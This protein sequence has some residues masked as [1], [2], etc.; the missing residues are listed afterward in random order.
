LQEKLTVGYRQIVRF[1]NNDVA[2]LR[3]RSKLTQH[4]GVRLQEPGISQHPEQ[5]NCVLS[6][7]R[8][9]AG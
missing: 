2:E 1:S 8:I 6:A 5:S 3:E 4:F 9:H 7:F